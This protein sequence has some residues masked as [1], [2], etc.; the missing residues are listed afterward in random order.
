LGIVEETAMEVAMG[1]LVGLV[2]LGLVLLLVGFVLVNYNAL[3]RSRNAYTKSFAQIDVQLTRRHDLIPNLVETAKGY[4]AHERQTLEAVTA[5]RSAA[6]TAQSSAAGAGAGS[7]A[8][9]DLAGAENVLTAALSRL[10]VLAEGYPTLKANQNMLD[11][12][13]EL[14]TS[15]NRIAFARQAYNDAVLNYN[16][17]RQVFPS[18]L[19]AAAFG[20]GPATLFELDDPQQRGTPQVSF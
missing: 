11:L 17:R 5:A 14:T 20:F 4:L 8:V 18:S 19:L 3:V 13:E 6:V 15:E 10:F 7:A 16:T 9:G 1:W 2:V 12:Q